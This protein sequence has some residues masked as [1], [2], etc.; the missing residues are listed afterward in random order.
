MAARRPGAPRDA[1]AGAVP[2]VVYEPS[3]PEE[4]AEALRECAAERR[5]V[6]FLGGGTEVG[7]GTPPES[8]GA[9]V[10]TGGL[11]RVVEYAPADQIVTV[12]AGVTLAALQEVLR[13]HRQRLALDP[14]LPERATV[15]GVIAAGSFGP[16]RTRYGTARDLIVGVSIVR[17]DGVLARGGGKVVKNVAG[18]DLPRLIVGSLGTLGLVTSATF[19]LHP[20]PEAAETARVGGLTAAA[21]RR[22]VV[23]MREAQ[24]EPSAVAAV[25]VG[26]F[27]LGVRFEGFGTAVV[28]QRKRLLDLA[29]AAGTAGCLLGE[30]EAGAF[31][32]RHDAVRAGGT[33]RLK[34]TAPASHFERVVAEVVGP[35]VAALDGAGLVAYPA[36]G[37]AFLGGTPREAG[38]SAAVVAA[39][40]LLE[41]F[42][43]ALVVQARP[44]ELVAGLDAWG[45][46]PAAIGLMRSLKQRFDPQRRLGAGRF[47]GGI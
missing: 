32:A 18:F 15:G 19:R 27:E 10:R 40:A 28:A 23:R 39:R 44:P 4:A 21:V 38:V 5:D 6:A 9:L 17:A 1:F 37:I 36:L 11:A 33:L 26:P 35:L 14:P 31:W 29:R 34:L 46:P 12:E 8:L 41:R 7:L 13:A 3:S 22:L 25:G 24:L 43:G 16:L 30:A 47:V 20:L 45:T 2:E 42:G